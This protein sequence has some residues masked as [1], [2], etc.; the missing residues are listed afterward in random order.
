MYSFSTLQNR[1]ASRKLDNYP[2][3]VEEFVEH[4]TFLSKIGS[5]LPALE[6][7]FCDG[8]HLGFVRDHPNDYLFTV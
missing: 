8:S 5:E 3:S 2:K 4:L 1:G 6:N 7:E